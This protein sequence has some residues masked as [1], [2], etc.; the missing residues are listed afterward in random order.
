MD[1]TCY[2]YIFYA[3]TVQYIMQE[4]AF[5]LY[6]NRQQKLCNAINIVST[7]KFVKNIHLL[8]RESLMFPHK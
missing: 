4:I 3:S 7:V 2:F 1:I 6:N 8:Q 5:L